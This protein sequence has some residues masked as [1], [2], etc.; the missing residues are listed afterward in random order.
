MN[1]TAIISDTSKFIALAESPRRFTLKIED[2]TITFCAISN[3]QA[4]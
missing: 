2:K 1:M 4:Q 3:P